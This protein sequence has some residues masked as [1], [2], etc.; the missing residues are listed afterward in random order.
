MYGAYYYLI[1]PTV[2]PIRHSLEPLKSAYQVGLETGDIEFASVCAL[3]YCS[4]AMG[5][6]LPLNHLLQECESIRDTFAGTRSKAALIL[7]APGLQA[8][9]HLMGMSRDPLAAKGEICDYEKDLEG[10]L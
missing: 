5:S 3:Q 8:V 9:H 2:N 10:K 1:G 6:G 7:I 4:L